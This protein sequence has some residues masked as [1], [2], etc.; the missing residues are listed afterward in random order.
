MF[1][2]HSGRYQY[3]AHICSGPWKKKLKGL[4]QGNGD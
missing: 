2:A 3:Q 4:E 1:V